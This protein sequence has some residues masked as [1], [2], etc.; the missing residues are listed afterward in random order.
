MRIRICF[1]TFRRGSQSVTYEVLETKMKKIYLS[2][3]KDFPL[4]GFS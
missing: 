4:D 2:E 1:K 3:L